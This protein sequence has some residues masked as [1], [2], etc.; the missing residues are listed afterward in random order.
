[1]NEFQ[2]EWYGERIILDETKTSDERYANGSQKQWQEYRE[3]LI[4]ERIEAH[5]EKRQAEADLRR[6]YKKEISVARDMGVRFLR[7]GAH[8]IA[9]TCDK[10]VITFA[11]AIKSPKDGNNDLYGRFIAA[12][13]YMNGIV[14]FVRK[15]PYQHNA[16]DCLVG[17]F[18]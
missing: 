14:A 13:R 16:R 1:M 6:H 15:P 12:E 10:D 4:K 2:K 5:A 8:T 7:V 18:W 17:M 11:T 9:Y 3:A